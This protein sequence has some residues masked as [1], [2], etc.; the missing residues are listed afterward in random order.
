MAELL[1]NRFQQVFTKESIFEKP[2]IREEK[3]YMEEIKV[4]K[5]EIYKLLEELEDEKAM[6]PDE[7]SGSLLKACREELTEPI[8]D[9]IRCSLES[10]KVPVEW[11]RAEV[12]PIYE[13]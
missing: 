4:T 5:G 10:G 13:W 8:Y 7:V 2:Q 3:V 12:V 9:I 11:K 6:G 1:N